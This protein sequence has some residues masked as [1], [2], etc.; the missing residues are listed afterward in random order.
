MP[1]N[2]NIRSSLL[3]RILSVPRLP[4]YALNAYDDTDSSS[5]GVIE[6]TIP[7]ETN[8]PI[9]V[10]RGSGIFNFG[11]IEVSNEEIS[12][13]KIIIDDV[14]VFD[15]QISGRILKRVFSNDNT[16]IGTIASN[17]APYLI[18]GYIEIQATNIT[19]IRG[20]DTSGII[21]ISLVPLQ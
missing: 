11:G 19:K 4:K 17:T 14:V 18:N 3:K 2:E 1:K 20:N 6:V 5:A 12:I 16:I 13:T 7:H 21:Y 8:T 10:I 15:S 9:T